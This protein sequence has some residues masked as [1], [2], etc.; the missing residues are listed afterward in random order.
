MDSEKLAV[1]SI[2]KLNIGG[3]SYYVRESTLLSRD[4]NS[5]L[6]TF[7]RGDTDSRLHHCDA[8]F[9]NANEYY[10]ER[11]PKLFEP[12]FKFY[13]T[14]QLHRPLDVCATDFSNEL[15]Y[16]NI[17][18]AQVSPC[19]STGYNIVQQQLL[20][21]VK[22]SIP[23][24][25][26][27]N[28]SLDLADDHKLAEPFGANESLRMRIH[29]FCE[30]DGTIASTLFSFASISF[31]LISVL[32]LVIGS[33]HE[34]QQ[35]IV[36]IGPKSRLANLSEIN[37][38]NSNIIWEPMPVFGYIETVC[39]LWFT[40]EYLLRFSVAPN[41]LQFVCGIMN[42]VD[43]I[44]IIPFYLEI[45][46]AICGIDFAS[47]SD[48][49][50]AL[51]VVRVLRVLRVV[52][53]LK[54]GRYSSGMRTFALTLKSSARQLGMM[55]MVLST[56]VVFFSTLLYFV[57]KDEVATPFTSIPAA[58]WWAIVTM[59]TVG[60]GDFVPVTIPGKLIA[61]GAIISGVLVLALPITIIVDNF[62][63]VSGN[64]NPNSIFSAQQP[65]EKNT[66]D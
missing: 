59:T 11:S 9:A 62:M 43:L 54:L 31:V 58:F 29:R 4:E 5:R 7:A 38:N 48:I 35:P 30:G 6:A 41:R 37:E 39:I 46:L 34:F 18:D 61:S 15:S 53:I 28:G 8:Y 44:A 36:K 40:L 50:G 45:S 3:T 66:C 25:P 26:Q 51:L 56:G 22:E 33:I 65:Q 17:P 63:K 64:A 19:C 16:W 10:F 52:R 21:T 1:D 14:G 2:I 42:I 24:F 27:M 23:D 12:I 20:A 13:V 32:G 60:Y 57:E 55:G 49:K 47:L